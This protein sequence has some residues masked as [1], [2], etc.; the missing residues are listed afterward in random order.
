MLAIVIRSWQ[1]HEMCLLYRLDSS[2]KAIADIF[3]ADPGADPWEADY[4]APGKFAPVIVQGK[5]GRRLVPRV[6]GV[7][8]PPKVLAAGGS[9]VHNVRNLDSPFWIGTLRHTE[10]RCLV[11]VTS[12][13]EW[14]GL[15]GQRTQHWYAVPSEPV[16]AFA[17]IW[18]DSEVLSFAFLTCDPNPMVA[19][20][21]A[22]S[23]PMILNPWDYDRWLTG[24]WDDART[25][26]GP[27]PSQLMA[28]TPM[29]PK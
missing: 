15:K 7:P 19:A 18:R 4:V 16:F 11:P 9:P 2:A 22:K 27:F 21:N 28:E 6:W 5:E 20:A 14:G 25:L 8:P 1:R 10:F 23:M 12:F 29:P 13:M 26:V 3:A 17:G 24:D